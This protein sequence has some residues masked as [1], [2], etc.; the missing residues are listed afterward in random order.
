MEAKKQRSGLRGSRL[1]GL[2][3]LRALSVAAVI[4]YHISGAPYFPSNRLLARVMGEGMM[5]V[6]VFF[7]ISGFLITWLLLEEEKRCGRISLGY[8]YLRRVLRILPP[9][10]LFLAVICILKYRGVVVERWGDIGR[11]AFFTRNLSKNISVTAHFWSL[12]IE[13]QYYLFWPILFLLVGRGGRLPLIVMAIVSVPIFR[14]SS[15]GGIGGGPDRRFQTASDALLIGVGLV[16]WRS[17]PSGSK[18]LRG[19]I[20]QSVWTLW[21]VLVIVVI[22]F[23]QPF[24]DHPISLTI[25]PV[26]KGTSI[27]VF[28]NYVVEGHR[29]LLSTILNSSVLIWI[30]QLSYSLYLWQQ[31]YCFNYFPWHWYNAFPANVCL[32]LLCAMG[33]FYLLERPMGRLRGKLERGR[34]T[35]DATVLAPSRGAL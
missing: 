32:S 9:A 3:G 26:I 22:G 29:G 21:G 24:H 16:L 1:P 19:K 15:L 14:Y 6:Q 12:A 7:V 25:L 2:D 27:A 10:F 31:L 35:A 30:G 13:E 34:R 18:F 33:S 5:G 17:T 4:A 20:M 8:F 11:S 28:I 23:V